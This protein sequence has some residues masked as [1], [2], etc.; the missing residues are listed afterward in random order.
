MTTNWL[1]QTTDDQSLTSPDDVISGHVTAAVKKRKEQKSFGWNNTSDIC[2]SVSV[3]EP[4]I[5]L[6]RGVASDDLTTGEV[7]YIVRDH[8][9][10]DV[11]AEDWPKTLRGG[12]WFND[13]AS[14]S[15]ALI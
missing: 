2:S 12:T 7:K 9:T 8:N 10:D 11:R 14:W 13:T 4:E 6:N 3:N 1:S 5:T 15:L